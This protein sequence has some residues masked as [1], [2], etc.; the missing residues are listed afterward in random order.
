MVLRKKNLLFLIGLALPGFTDFGYSADASFLATPLEEEPEEAAR[1]ATEGALQI[2]QVKAGDATV[3]AYGGEFR[4][5]YRLSEKWDAGMG[6]QQVLSFRAGG[7]AVLSNTSIKAR[8]FITGGRVP[9]GKRYIAAGIPRVI[10][11][12]PAIGGLA[13]ALALDQT[14]FNLGSVTRS[15]SGGGLMLNYYLA[16]KDRHL[17]GIGIGG[18][19]ISNGEQSLIPLRVELA[20]GYFLK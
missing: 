5:W 14:T 12:V 4:V 16:F 2:N 10:E 6:L 8:Y 17:A 15:Y 19:R 1:V 11:T 13:L 20:W 3:V 9:T 7:T 18:S